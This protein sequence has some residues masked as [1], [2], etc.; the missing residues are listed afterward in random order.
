MDFP[1]LVAFLKSLH[2]P[3]RSALQSKLEL[4]GVN[5]LASSAYLSS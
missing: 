1:D 5:L 4:R 2:A 3:E